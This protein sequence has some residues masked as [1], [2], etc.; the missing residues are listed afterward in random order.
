M[1]LVRLYCVT[2]VSPLSHDSML[3]CS[4]QSPLTR[5]CAQHAFV[6]AVL[7]LKRVS[8]PAIK[9]MWSILGSIVGVVSPVV[10]TAVWLV[11]FNSYR[12][13]K[14]MLVKQVVKNSRL[15][16]IC[17]MQGISSSTRAGTANPMMTAAASGNSTSIQGQ[18]LLSS[19]PSALVTNPV[20]RGAS[21][22]SAVY[23][24][25]D[26]IMLAEPA[27][28]ISDAAREITLRCL[29]RWDGFM[30]LRASSDSLGRRV[31]IWRERF[32][33]V[34]FASLLLAFRQANASLAYNQPGNTGACPLATYTYKSG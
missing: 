16:D 30:G 1:P 7:S 25:D 14:R 23:D 27:E 28:D 24:P 15:P 31:G 21:A 10:G 26:P 32:D 4:S 2:T 3:P 17:S 9:K 33:G 34:R 13:E 11:L 29:Q 19:P 20:H 5:A 6:S 8:L 22:A 12:Q 18:L